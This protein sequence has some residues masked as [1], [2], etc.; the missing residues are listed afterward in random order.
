M[1]A[2][3][4][5]HKT[6]TVVQFTKKRLMLF[7]ERFGI[8]PLLR[9]DP[10]LG[11]PALRNKPMGTVPNCLREP[12]ESDP[13]RATL[14]DDRDDGALGEARMEE[15]AGGDG[16]GVL[17]DDTRLVCRKRIAAVEDRVRGKDR[18]L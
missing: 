14:A 13:H 18:E 9:H 8:L 16:R 10:V 4:S 2:E 11:K 12:T 6:P 5:Y 1:S 15:R 7:R 3:I 17:E